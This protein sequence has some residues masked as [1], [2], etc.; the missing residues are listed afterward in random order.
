MTAI[1]SLAWSL[2]C[3]LRPSRVSR[4]PTLRA[5]TSAKLPAPIVHVH[6]VLQSAWMLLLLVQMLLVSAKCVPLHRKLGIAGFLL[7]AAMVAVAQMVVANQLHRLASQGDYR[8]SYSLVPQWEVFNFAVLAGSALDAVLEPL[9]SVPVGLRAISN[10]AGHFKSFVLY[11]F[12]LFEHTS[13]AERTAFVPVA[14]V[15]LCHP[16][17]L[18]LFPFI[19]PVLPPT[20]S[21]ITIDHDEF[22]EL[23]FSQ[24]SG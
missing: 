8:L 6:A 23:P 9:R 7:A 1:S 17:V 19:N 18:S 5:W 12:A 4:R 22:F 3:S 14:S 10:D 2:H 13:S 24:G 11:I 16:N 20:I 15:H 21:S